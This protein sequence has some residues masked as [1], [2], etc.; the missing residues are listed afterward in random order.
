MRRVGA[1][2]LP[3]KLQDLSNFDTAV[4]MDCNNSRWVCAFFTCEREPHTHVTLP[5]PGKGCP[6]KKHIE[7]EPLGPSGP[8]CH[9]RNKG[10]RSRAAPP[11]Y[12]PYTLCV[13]TRPKKL[14]WVARRSG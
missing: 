6:N 12:E 1:R 10:L 13:E 9:K 8:R 2:N 3:D 4:I 11:L 14:G 7:R 5:L